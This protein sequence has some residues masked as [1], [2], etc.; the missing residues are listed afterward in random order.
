MAEETQ[1]EGCPREPASEAT[2]APQE[3][4]SQEYGSK[5]DYEAD[6]Q[7]LKKEVDRLRQS[8]DDRAKNVAS[9]STEVRDKLAKFD[10]TVRALGPLMREGV[11][12]EEIA[13]VRERQFVQNLMQQSTS[14]TPEL[15][16]SSPPQPDSPALAS[17]PPGR[18]SEIA[19]I[20]EAHSLKNAP[21]ELLEYAEANKDE[22]WW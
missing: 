7:T 15:E 21:P 17:V 16:E 19:A 5:S 13:Q 20:L 8:S 14:D 18:E 12:E 4:P 3:T 11:G 1:A 2:E 10:E 22:P 6:L 9:V